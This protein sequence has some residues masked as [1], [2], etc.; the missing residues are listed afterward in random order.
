MSVSESLA[1]A[2][3]R[4]PYGRWFSLF[5]A[6]VVAGLVGDGHVSW[7][8]RISDID[9]GFALHDPYP[10]AEVTIRLRAP[11]GGRRGE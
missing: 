3:H 2:S 6:T 10:T 5:A 4:R 1:A 11:Q 7:E 8:S 9:P